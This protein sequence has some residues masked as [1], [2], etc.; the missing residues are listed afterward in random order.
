M[1]PAPPRQLPARSAGSFLASTALLLMTGVL[2]FFA[3]RDFRD[4]A[5][6]TY[7]DLE[8]YAVPIG[9]Y[10]AVVVLVRDQR[11]RVALVAGAAGA[12]GGVGFFGVSDATGFLSDLAFV[13][14]DALF[15]GLMCLLLAAVAIA[16][17]ESR[18]TVRQA[19]GPAVAGGA[20]GAALAYGAIIALAVIALSR[21]GT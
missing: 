21:C 19:V 6:P 5:L 12:L 17:W 3:V 7:V 15:W 1:N 10:A 13:R 4:P 2:A 9:A 11:L 18:L 8:I 20:L 16:W 14:A